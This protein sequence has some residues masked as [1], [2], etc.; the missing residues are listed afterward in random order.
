MRSLSARRL[1]LALALGLGAAAP[2]AAATFIEET[3][4][5]GGLAIDLRGFAPCGAGGALETN[6][7]RFSG[8]GP[9]GS[10]GAAC[11]DT[12]HVQ[13]KSPRTP[14]AYGRFDPDGGRWIDSNDLERVVWEVDVGRPVRWVAFALTDA[15]DQPDS[16]FS[17]TAQGT[18]WSIAEREPNATLHLIRILFDAPVET[19]EVVFETRHNDGFGIVAATAAPVPLPPALLLAASGVAALGVLR[20]R[21]RP[22]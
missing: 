15:H 5:A 21:R 3:R 14:D 12:R 16:H 18:T 22:A 9:A 19:A 13:V 8:S 20:R 2:A 11:G 4:P 1:G 17:I 10:G 7:G 6:L